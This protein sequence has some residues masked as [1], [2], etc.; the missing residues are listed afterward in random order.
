MLI[1]VSICTILGIITALLM[2]P[3]FRSEARIVPE[4]NS[5][6]GDMFKRLA[7]VAGFAGMD[8]SEEGLDAVRPD[9]YPNVLQSMPFRLF[10]IEQRITTTNGQ[11]TTVAE[12]LLPKQPGE[13]WKWLPSFRKKELI[14]LPPTGRSRPLYISAREQELAEDI[15]ERVNARL[16]TRSGIITI[17]AQMPDALVAA[18]VAQRAMDYLTQYVISYRTGKAREDARFYEQ[19]L[20]EAQQR[21]QMA[22][23][24][25]FQ[26][27]DHH[28]YV[29]MQAATME[30]QRMEAELSIAQT[31]YAELARQFE[32]ARLKI[33]E[34]TPVFK[35]LE[36]AQI[37]HKR[38]SPKRTILVLLSAVI[39]LIIGIS[40]AVAHHIKP[41]NQLRSIIVAAE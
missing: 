5:T 12:F 9:L 10:L 27:N 41:I 13:W 38:A 37:P 22:Q 26:Y 31:V 18:T 11:S 19:R 17:T 3:E 1:I 39:G 36:P 20:R 2:K 23:L 8:F 33:Q 4:M 34:R 15:S 29:V 25:I 30:K 6:S 7:S 24:R 14:K 32:Q 35:V 40:Y 28:K 16:D 21:Y